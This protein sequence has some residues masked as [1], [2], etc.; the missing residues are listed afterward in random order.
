M[1]E[2]NVC[3]IDDVFGK[4]EDFFFNSNCVVGGCRFFCCCR[5]LCGVFFLGRYEEIIKYLD[6]ILFHRRH[7]VAIGAECY[8]YIAV[9]ED[10]LNNFRVDSGEHQ[11]GGAGVAKIVDPH[12]GEADLLEDSV[13]DFSQ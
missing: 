10:F 8:G 1:L 7:G 9:T 2:R 6:S 11:D 12:S 3:Q 5:L 13:Q 4:P